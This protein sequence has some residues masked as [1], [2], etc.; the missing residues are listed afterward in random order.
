MEY[1]TPYFSEHTGEQIDQGVKIARE[2]IPAQLAQ[3]F[4]GAN[5]HV[6]I[7]EDDFMKMLAEGAVDLTK[8]YYLYSDTPMIPNSLSKIYFGDLLFA[9]RSSSDESSGF[10]YD[11]PII[12]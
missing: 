1:N 6:H 11:F 12:F 7:L 5:L 4:A 2:T 10:P 9:Q 8:Y 3:L